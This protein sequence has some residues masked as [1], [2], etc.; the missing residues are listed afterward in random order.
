[1]PQANPT[2]K[3][4]TGAL[5]AIPEG[6]PM[7]ASVKNGVFTSWRHLRFCTGCCALNLMPPGPDLILGLKVFGGR[8][9][10][11]IARVFF[12]AFPSTSPY[13]ELLKQFALFCG[14]GLLVALLMMTYGLDLSA[15][16]F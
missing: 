11:A 7:F 2:I 14:A 4:N 15:G 5:I 3:F 12:R 16:F 13:R 1:M 9:L 8:D 6:R 10:L